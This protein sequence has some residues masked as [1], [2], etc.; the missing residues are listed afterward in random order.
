MNGTG[1]TSVDR[2]SIEELENGF[3]SF[4]PAAL[5]DRISSR[6][7]SYHAFSCGSDS[8]LYAARTSLNVSPASAS[9]AFLSGWYLSANFRYAFLMAV[10]SAFNEISRTS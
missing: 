10:E 3:E 8:T 6:C 1:S 7:A 9:F 4:S 2:R 5:G